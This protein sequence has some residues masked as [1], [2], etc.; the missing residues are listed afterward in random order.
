[1]NISAASLLIAA[2]ISPYSANSHEPIDY[3]GLHLPLN[4]ANVVGFRKCFQYFVLEWPD[5]ESGF[6]FPQL[7]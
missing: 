2:H 5:F 7:Y 1:M 4:Q 6:F 3:Q